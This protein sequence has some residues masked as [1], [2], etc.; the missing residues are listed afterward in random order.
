VIGLMPAI[1]IGPPAKLTIDARLVGS[2]INKDALRRNDDCLE[3]R[4]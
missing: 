2:K 4:F 1:L 3:R